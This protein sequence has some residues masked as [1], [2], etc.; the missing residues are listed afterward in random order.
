[1]SGVRARR[2]QS[3]VS[4]MNPRSRPM[5][6]WLSSQARSL[7]RRSHAS[8]AGRV[9]LEYLEDR[10]LLT[11][12]GVPDGLVSLWTADSTAADQTGLNNATLTGVTYAVGEVGKAFSFDGLNDW[13]ALGDPGSLAFT[14]SFTIEGWIKVNGPPTNS[15]FGSIMFRG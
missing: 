14:A 6:N 8:R 13:A 15:N 12:V 5:R 1:M 3:P 2:R 11:A 9:S 10:Q 4:T 7:A